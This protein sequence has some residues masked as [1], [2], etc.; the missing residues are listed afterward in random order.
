VWCL[1]CSIGKTNTIESGGLEV[2]LAAVN[3][4]LGSAYICQNACLALSD[5]VKE[6]K[7]NTKLLIS[8]GGATAVA[9]VSTEWPDNNDVQTPMRKLANLIGAEMKTW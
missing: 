6:S 2:L 5:I 7:E 3:N 4:H 9:K 1:C 8:L